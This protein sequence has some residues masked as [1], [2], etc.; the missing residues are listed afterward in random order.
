MKRTRVCELLGIEYPII[1]APM[2]WITNADLAAAVSNA[3]GLG[4][5]GP[6]AGE[7]TVTESVMETGDRLH[8]EIR[9]LRSLTARPFG[10]NLITV[11]AEMDFSVGHRAFSD[12]CLKVILQEAVPV[13]VLTGS[14]PESYTEQ[15][16]KAG[17]KV[18]YRA[19]PANITTAIRGEQAGVD[20]FVAVGL[21]GGG[22]TGLDCIPTFV[23]IPQI[24]DALQIPVVGGGGIADG[25]GVAAALSLG[26]EGVFIGTRFIATEECPAHLAVK[27]A[28]VHA[29]ELSTSTVAG[30]VG[31]L[32]ALRTPVM[33]RCI[34]ME[35][36]GCSLQEISD[37]YD[38]V[39]VKGML[40]GCTAEGT[41]VCGA[42][43]GLIRE[44]KSAAEVVRDLAAETDNIL[45][46][47]S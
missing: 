37:T 26:A 29:C 12:E 20:M 27:H 5:I 41:I 23:L 21:E 15:L 44:M 30:I 11:E 22:H 40:D 43:A 31:I 33:E 8:R 13:V 14:G 9:K 32:R 17:V 16:K 45:N 34:Q 3:G 25:R 28:I 24:V 38:S 19:M 10:V 36:A 7:R 39:Y 42:G 35:K 18:L 6:N 1:Q 4:V 47:L 46:R 2:N